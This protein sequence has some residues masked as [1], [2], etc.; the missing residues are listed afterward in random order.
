MSAQQS[1]GVIVFFH[2]LFAQNGMDIGMARAADPQDLVEYFSEAVIPSGFAVPT[3]RD[4]V[5]TS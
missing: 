2:I 1:M 4:Q 3:S 5:M